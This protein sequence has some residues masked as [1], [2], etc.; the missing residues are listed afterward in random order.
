M[1]ILLCR[2]NLSGLLEKLFGRLVLKNITHL[3][4]PFINIIVTKKNNMKKLFTLLSFA[5]I[6][7][8]CS[9]AKVNSDYGQVKVRFEN[10][11]AS[12]M[13]SVK[14]T[15]VNYGNIPVGNT[16]VY[17]MLTEP[18]YAAY[19]TH[20]IN[21]TETFTGYG[22]CGSPMPPPFA[23]G[24]YTFRVEQDTAEYYRIIVTKQ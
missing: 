17:R 8:S 24:Y 2:K 6:I 13:R 19:Y 1:L 5:A 10:A 4:N 12:T 9:K 23:A 20:L 18:I 22:V 15:S 11:T 16:T 14:I 21:D 7:L 3:C